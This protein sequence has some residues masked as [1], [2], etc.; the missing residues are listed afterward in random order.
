M[1]FCKTCHEFIY[2]S[3]HICPPMWECRIGDDE[4]GFEYKSYGNSESEA[5]EK[6]AEIKESD[7]DYVFVEDGGVNI[8]VR[9]PETGKV[10]SFYVSAEQTISY[11]ASEK[12]KE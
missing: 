12:K 8:D 2:T 4:E 6:L 10:K 5:A 7:W 3:S 11:Y 9:N 1:S